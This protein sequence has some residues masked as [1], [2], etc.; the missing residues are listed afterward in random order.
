MNQRPPNYQRAKSAFQS[1]KSKHRLF[2]I[3][4]LPSFPPTG[5]EI[6]QYMESAANNGIGCVI[7]RL[8]TNLP[9]SAELLDQ[10]AAF[11]ETFIATAEKYGVKIGL[12][13]EPVLEEAFYMSPAAEAIP[14]TRSRSLIRRQYFCDP[15]EQLYLQ[16]RKGTSMS[17]MAYDDEHTDMIDLRPYIQDDTVSYTVPDGNWTVEEYIC[18]TEPQYGEP[19]NHHC[20]ILSYEH[21]AEYLNAL[22]D[23]LGDSVRTRLGTTI[24]HW[25]LV[26]YACDVDNN[27]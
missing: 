24:N 15:K 18:T 6:L 20:N 11:Y 1:V 17:V 19:P 25:D 13:L 8:P 27:V 14:H 22:F 3:Y 23:C 16:L 5:E 26:H 10:V 12:Y 4:D 7:P 21:S 2:L 9:P